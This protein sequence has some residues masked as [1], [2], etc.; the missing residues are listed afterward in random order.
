M[1]GAG[2]Q[3]WQYDPLRPVNPSD[4]A[5]SRLGG[6]ILT[7]I[8]YPSPRAARSPPLRCIRSRRR[9]TSGTAQRA[10]SS[11]TIVDRLHGTCSAAQHEAR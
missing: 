10:A 4:P 5:S 2:R 6:G 3:V 8:T 11:L 1:N 9:G 7:M